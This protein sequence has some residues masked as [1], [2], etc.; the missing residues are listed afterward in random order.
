[1]GL[2]DLQTK[3]TS[4]SRF[5]RGTIQAIAFHPTRP[6]VASVSENDRQIRLSEV[7]HAAGQPPQLKEAWVLESLNVVSRLCFTPDGKRLAAISQDVIKLW[8]P[9]SRLEM[10]TL[11][12]ILRPFWEDPQPL[13]VQFSH[14]GLSLVAT[15]WDDSLS[16]WEAEPPRGTSSRGEAATGTI[17]EAF[18]SPERAAY[19]HLT[20]AEQAMQNGNLRAT[21]FHLNRMKQI[22][23]MPRSL[24]QR[25]AAVE[26]RWKTTRT[27][28]AA[29]G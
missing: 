15:N 23:S 19:W 17:S 3:Q 29:G 1:L 4:I 12:G 2:V 25:R 14:D 10:L 7:H 11:R 16:L 9:Q 28:K 20:E 6:I 22:P 13:L 5:H 21:E 24:E 18:L 27:G 26:Q 8:D